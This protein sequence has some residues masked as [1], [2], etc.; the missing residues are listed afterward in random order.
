MAVARAAPLALVCAL[1][2][3]LNPTLWIVSAEHVL[4]LLQSLRDLHSFDIETQ[5]QYYS[6]LLV[7]RTLTDGQS[8]SVIEE[9]QLKAFVNSADWN[10]GAISPSICPTSG[11]D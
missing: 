9:D 11:F 6:P 4:P 10:L 2:H 7:E 3:W 5:V 1:G 8:G